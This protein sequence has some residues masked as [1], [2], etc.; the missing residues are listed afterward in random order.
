[1]TDLDDR[2]E[3]LRDVPV[4]SGADIDG[5]RRRVQRRRN[6]R[7]ARV[8]LAALFL[9]AGTAVAVWPDDGPREIVAVDAPRTADVQQL[10]VVYGYD[11]EEHETTFDVELGRRVDRVAPAWSS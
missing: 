5:L 7:A 9:A 2:L 3:S 8:G 4:P 10:R 6:R 1:M 11:G